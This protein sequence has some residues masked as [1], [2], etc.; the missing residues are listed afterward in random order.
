MI[1]GVHAF[2]WDQI[3]IVVLAEE[4]KHVNVELNVRMSGKSGQLVQSHVA[5][6]FGN[7]SENVSTKETVR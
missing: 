4:V 3:R 5:L 2:A 1:N 7:E 6:A